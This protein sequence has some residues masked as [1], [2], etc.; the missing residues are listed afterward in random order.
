MPLRGNKLVIASMGCIHEQPAVK[1]D[2]DHKFFT[3][4]CSKH[5]IL[6]SE[7]RQVVHWKSKVAQTIPYDPNPSSKEVRPVHPFATF[8][9]IRSMQL[10]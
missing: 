9:Q 4:T 6:P 2:A 10:W 8:M 3:Y 1:F 5:V 7:T